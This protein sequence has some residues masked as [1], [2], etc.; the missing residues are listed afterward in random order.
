MGFFLHRAVWHTRVP[1]SGGAGRVHVRQRAGLPPRGGHVG[2]RRDHV[3]AAVWRAAV[4]APQTDADA[5]HD[6]AGKLQVWQPRVG[7]RWGGS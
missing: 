4:L 6:H 2:V 5:A 3:H 7:R 1:S